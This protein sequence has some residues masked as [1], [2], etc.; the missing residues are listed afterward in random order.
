MSSNSSIN[1]QHWNER[2]LTSDT[3]LLTPFAT[4]DVPRQQHEPDAEA[5]RKSRFLADNQYAPSQNRLAL[6]R[7]IDSLLSFVE[8]LSMF[9]KDRLDNL[10][11]FEVST[12]RIY[13]GERS[14]S[15][16]GRGM[17]FVV[18]AEKNNKPQTENFVGV[19]S[20]RSSKLDLVAVKIP[21][22][23]RKEFLRFDPGLEIRCLQAIAWECHVLCHPPIRRCKN[24][25]HLNGITWRPAFA[26]K[27]GKRRLLPALV[28]EFASEGALSDYFN[29]KSYCLCY[30]TKWKLVLGIAEGLRTLHRHGIIHGDVKAENV[31]LNIEANGELIPKLSDFACSMD[32][33]G[34]LKEE[35][36]PGRSPPWDAPE[37]RHGPIAI[38]KLHK[39]DI[40]SFG[41]LVWRIMLEGQT[42][43]DTNTPSMRY[44]GFDNI[45]RETER[46]GKLLAIQRLKEQDGDELLACMKTTLS[47][48]GL[49]EPQL[50]R[51]FDL[52]IR[53]QE[54]DRVNS[55]EE[56]LRYL[57]TADLDT[58]DTIPSDMSSEAEMVSRA[59]DAVLY[60]KP[61]G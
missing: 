40:Y 46:S 38:S 22:I 5:Q 49:N 58:C 26:G 35:K 28:M 43:F 41:L 13:G 15:L 55:V 48:R 8:Y 52:T 33:S 11:D 1:S 16:V 19:P 9:P 27:D 4:E 20:W 18:Q 30:S 14:F 32:D 45:M 56:L 24:I 10:Y 59:S 17:S 60:V 34:S 37:A 7:S 3:L 39:T 25:I 54:N 36:L 53:Y 29:P 44:P 51:L 23:E 6:L 2:V 50:S 21:R 12:E 42:P 31:L 57:K 61:S 47:E